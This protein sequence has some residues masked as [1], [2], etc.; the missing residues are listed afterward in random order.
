MKTKENNTFK[1]VSLGELS[2]LGLIKRI[3]EYVNEAPE[4]YYRLMIGTD[5]L[6]SNNGQALF[7]TAIVVH[8]VGHGGIYFWQKNYKKNIHTLRDRMYEEAMF[9][10]KTAQAIIAHKKSLD[11]MKKKVEIHLDIGDEGETR[12]MIKE[13][14]GMVVANGFRYQIKPFSFAASKV[15]DRHTVLVD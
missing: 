9:S 14:V 12:E 5:S 1:S 10:M 8:R 11:F 4:N 3:S 13:I 6:P 15:A 7:V 2:Y